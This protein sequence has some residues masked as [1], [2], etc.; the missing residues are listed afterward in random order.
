[1]WTNYLVQCGILFIVFTKYIIRVIEAN[2]DRT[3]EFYVRVLFTRAEIG[4]P[5][6][7]IS[8]LSTKI[9]SD[10][11]PDL[12]SLPIVSLSLTLSTL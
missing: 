11:S 10:S 4:C 7:I 9:S 8:C 12:W 1:M 5:T 2:V 6:G 3:I